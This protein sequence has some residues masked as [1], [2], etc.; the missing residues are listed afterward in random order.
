MR[1][2]RGPL[3]VLGDCLLDIDLTGAIRR[4]SPDTGVPVVDV[5]RQRVR[6]G[7]AGL[8]AVLAAQA[9]TE[10]VLVTA[11]ADD[12]S[13]QLLSDLLTGRVE[14]CALPSTGR[15]ST[16]IRVSA[17]H[18]LVRLDSGDGRAAAGQLP[19]PARRALATAGGILVADYGRGVARRADLAGL[20]AERARQ[21]PVVWDPHP[22]GPV[23][24]RGCRLITPNLSEAAGRRGWPDPRR[25]AERLLASWKADAVAVTLGERGAVLAEA[26]PPRTA[27]VPVPSAGPPATGELDPCGAGDQL[28]VTSACCLMQGAEVGDAVRAGV[29]EASAFVRAGGVARISTELSMTPVLAGWTAAGRVHDLDRTG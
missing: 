1:A 5:Q 27:W 15:T 9:A 18:P 23:P 4:R 14:V 8:A 21:V 25:V 12:D 19:E 20:I 10:V 6:P 3:V 17:E 11:L 24:V 26:R 16:K 29:R 2:N 7:G 28:A 22:H 13:G